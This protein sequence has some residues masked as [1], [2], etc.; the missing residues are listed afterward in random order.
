[1]SM[2]K[3][4]VFEKQIEALT[5]ARL[6]KTRMKPVVHEARIT[7]LSE[8]A[9]DGDMSS[10]KSFISSKF[11]N[12]EAEMRYSEFGVT[13]QDGA[14][15]VHTLIPL[16]YTSA[17]VDRAR[18]LWCM[19]LAWRGKLESPRKSPEEWRSY[20]DGQLADYAF[21]AGA[22]QAIRTWELTKHVEWRDRDGD[23]WTRG[24]SLGECLMNGESV[25][26]WCDDEEDHGRE[27]YQEVRAFLWPELQE[28]KS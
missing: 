22:E 27:T 21:M 11:R 14:N 16:L 19:A 10:L 23:V 9:I 6:V 26:H 12:K 18:A 7:T 1:M 25:E 2:S 20:T 15:L 28:K 4:D 24:S 13:E 8:S 3:D 5:Y 17:Y